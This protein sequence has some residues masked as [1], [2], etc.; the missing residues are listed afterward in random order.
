MVQLIQVINWVT[1]RKLN[2]PI[3][4]LDP[5]VLSLMTWKIKVYTI[6]LCVHDKAFKV[7]NKTIIVL[8]NISQEYIDVYLLY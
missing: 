8:K 6:T 3:T 1:Q 7:P 2:G 5:L 4:G